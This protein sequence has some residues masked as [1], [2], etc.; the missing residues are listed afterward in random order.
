MTVVEASDLLLRGGRADTC[1]HRGRPARVKRG[2]ERICTSIQRN[3]TTFADGLFSG[4]GR[5]QRSAQKVSGFLAPS[6]SQS[7][8]QPHVPQIDR[9]PAR[10]SSEPAELD[11]PSIIH[12][13]LGQSEQ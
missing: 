12:D 1:T 9:Y 11:D 7:G 3:P 2:D 6:A 13:K 8:Y 10:G 5:P 4:I